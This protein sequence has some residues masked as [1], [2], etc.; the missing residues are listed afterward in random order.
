V[1][2]VEPAFIVVGGDLLAFNTAQELCTLSGRRAVVLWHGDP[3]F[4]RAMEC[5]G[6]VFITAY[7]ESAEGL[8]RAGVRHA[9]TILA[10][11][12]NDQVNLHTALLARDPN[13]GGARRL[14]R[15]RATRK[16][17]FAT[18]RGIWPG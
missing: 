6:A 14:W 8:E 4:V 5:V 10:L 13:P 2:P 15:N 9:A 18:T 3:E 11:S 7:P 16:N 12:P 1:S 17:R